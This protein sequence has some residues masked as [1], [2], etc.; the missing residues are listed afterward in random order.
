MTFVL[1]GPSG[2]ILRGL[3]DNYA[4]RL[5]V[6][7]V[8]H[9]DE[10]LEDEAYEEVLAQLVSYLQQSKALVSDVELDELTMLY[11]EFE[12]ETEALDHLEVM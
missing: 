6:D 2:E 10:L 3:S 12:L 4:D 7:S 9:L 1:S 5:D 8:D 11:E